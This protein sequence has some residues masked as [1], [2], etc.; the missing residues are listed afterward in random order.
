M[1]SE[2]GSGIRVAVVG[3]GYW[4]SK[5]V[6][7]LNG[8]QGV[9]EVTLVDGLK[10]RLE[11]LAGSY[12]TSPSYTDLQSA[13]PQVDAVVVATPPSTHVGI[14]LEAIEAGKPGRCGLRSRRD[15]DGRPHLRVQPRGAKAP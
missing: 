14:A 13:L 7:V 8:T 5:H 10:D 11:K 4:G 3:C 12:K 2:S 1:K 15:P 9:T 6:R